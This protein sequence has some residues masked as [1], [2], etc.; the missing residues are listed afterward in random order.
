MVGERDREQEEVSWELDD[1][2]VSSI[3]PPFNNGVLPYSKS[4]QPQHFPMA[5]ADAD[6]SGRWYDEKDYGL[7]GGE[8]IVGGTAAERG[9]RFPA[10]SPTNGFYNSQLSQT[11]LQN[12]HS[13]YTTNLLVI[14]LGSNLLNKN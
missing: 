6:S 1:T 4:Q 11:P 9:V 8:G 5:S 14:L 2:A 3:P 13:R 10:T 7:M 12:T